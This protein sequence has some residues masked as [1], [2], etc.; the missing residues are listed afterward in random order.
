MIYNTNV[1]IF[2]PSNVYISEVQN[3]LNKYKKKLIPSNCYMY[4]SQ[5]LFLKYIKIFSQ[6]ITHIMAR[7]Y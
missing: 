4:N 2:V 6:M 7:I 5:D 1:K 3:L